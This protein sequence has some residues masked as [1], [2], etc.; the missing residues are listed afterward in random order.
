MHHVHLAVEAPDGS[1][2]MFV[3]KPRKERHLLLAPTVATVRAGR[4][5]VPVLSLAWRTTKLPTRETLGTWAPADADMEVLEVSGE[6]DRAKVIAEVLKARTEPLSNVADLQ[7]G[8]MEENDRDLMLQLMRN[9]PALIEPRKGCPPM[10]TLGVEHE[11]HTGDAA[12]IKVRPR[13]HAHT[14]QL[15]VDAEVDQMLNDGVVEEG[16]GAG[17]FPVVLV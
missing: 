17:G 4:I 1:V 13:R 7:M 2:G 5:T 6:L 16:N 10:T 11:I 15:V 14:E 8:D 12:P 9:Y 3:P